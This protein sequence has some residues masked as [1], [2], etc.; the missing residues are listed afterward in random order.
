MVAVRCRVRA[1]AV[2]TSMGR[3]MRRLAWGHYPREHRVTAGA[4]PTVHGDLGSSS[5]VK[6]ASLPT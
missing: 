6:C 4:H 5:E 3:R 2:R 1:S